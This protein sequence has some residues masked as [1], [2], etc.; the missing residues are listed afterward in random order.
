MKQEGSRLKILPAI[1]EPDWGGRIH[2]ITVTVHQDQLWPDAVMQV[3]GPD[4]SNVSDVCKVGHLYLP[5]GV[6]KKMAKMVLVSLAGGGDFAKAVAWAEKFDLKR[7]N[8]RQ[9][10]AIGE[11]MPELHKEIGMD[12]MYVIASEECFFE[13][14]QQI[15]DVWWYGSKRRASLDWVSLAR[16]SRDWVAFLCE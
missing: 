9:V 16:G 14:C 7:T 10:F 11:K 5:T 12:P 1:A 6:G 3:V 8:P 13:G 4:T 15:C 2:Y